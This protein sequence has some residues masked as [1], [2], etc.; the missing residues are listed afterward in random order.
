MRTSVTR[1]LDI[2]YPVGSDGVRFRDGTAPF[3]GWLLA[4]VD[5]H[6]TV[7]NVGAGPTPPESQ[8]HMRGRVGR[9]VGVD[10]DPV[11]LTNSDLDEAYVNDGVILPF[12]DG[13]FD[14]VFSDWTLEHVSA[15]AAFL[16]EVHRVLRPGGFFWFR[17]PNRW[18]YVSLLA[19]ITP[20]WVHGK[21]ANRARA[22]GDDAHEPWPT[23]YRLNDNHRLRY[24]L[25]TAGYDAVEIRRIE[26]Y[27]SYLVFHP[28]AFQL[29]V[30]YERLVNRFAMLSRLRHTMIG[31]ARRPS[32]TMS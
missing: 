26:S 19:A 10:P 25:S 22:L 6:S 2:Y 16:S 29:G 1:L 8:R 15:P 12:A 24:L 11:V 5:N 28:L 32:Q 18:H 30:R 3:Y 9:L 14:A 21:I 27:P 23:L 31:R 7:L 20:H 4:H 13:V 17:T